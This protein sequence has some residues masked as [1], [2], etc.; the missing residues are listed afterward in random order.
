[1]SGSLAVVRDHVVVAGM[2]AFKTRKTR[3]S[4]L[5]FANRSESKILL[6]GMLDSFAVQFADRFKVHYCIDRVENPETW[7]G[8][9]G[10]L[11]KQMIKDTMP[12]PA[13]DIKMLVCGPDKMMHNVVGAKLGVMKAMSGG[14]A[15]QPTAANLNNI[16]D[17]QGFLGDLGYTKEMVYRF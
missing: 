14:L 12:A 9:V 2:R 3:P 16:Q 13:E 11:S 15:M 10:Y 5:L 17:V 1:M 4:C 6:R 8:Y 7:K